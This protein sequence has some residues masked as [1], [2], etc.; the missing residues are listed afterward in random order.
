M[1]WPS[2][3]ALL[4]QETWSYRVYDNIS[5]G[6]VAKKELLHHYNLTR[7]LG[8]GEDTRKVPSYELLSVKMKPK[9]RAL[10]LGQIC[11]TTLWAQISC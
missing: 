6:V 8:V 10:L 9:R 3:S 5:I 7:H 1:V 4:S 2:C 11:F